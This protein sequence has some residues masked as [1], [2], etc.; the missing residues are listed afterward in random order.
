VLEMVPGDPDHVIKIERLRS[1]A[2]GSRP[3]LALLLLM[4]VRSPELGLVQAIGASRSPDLARTDE[5]DPANSLV[6]FGHGTDTRARERWRDSSRRVGVTPARN[7]GRREGESGAL[8]LGLAPVRQ[9]EC[10]GLTQGLETG[11]IWPGTARGRRGCAAELRQ[12]RNSHDKAELKETEH[13]SE[14]LT[15]GRHS[16]RLGAAFGGLH[17]RHGGHER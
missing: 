9:G 1:N 7:P 16:G 5:K 12:G 6:G 2:R 13:G 3:R 14:F 10:H 8:R 4:M 17:G 15:S 11:P